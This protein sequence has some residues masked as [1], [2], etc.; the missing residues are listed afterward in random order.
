M[1]VKTGPRQP[2][3]D[4]SFIAKQVK[5]FM[6]I[7]GWRAIRNQRMVLPGTFQSG[8]PG[9]PDYCFIR[10]LK[11]GVALVLWVE[12][13]RP[14]YTDN[15][16]C[17]RIQGTR[18]RCTPCDQKMWR[19]RERRNGGIVWIVD[20]IGTFVERYDKDYGWLHA[21]ETGTGQLDMLA[22]LPA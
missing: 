8:E 18:K 1:R 16:R 12:M 19:T 20:D 17:A 21:P 7:K 11:D 22:G 5:D 10:Y 6:L 13:K 15:H 14:G 4:E 9:I 2:R 3:L